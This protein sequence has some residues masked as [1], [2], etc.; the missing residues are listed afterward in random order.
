M[1]G[2][3]QGQC[4]NCFAVISVNSIGWTIYHGVGPW[5]WVDNLVQN[6]YNIDD[7]VDSVPHL[8]SFI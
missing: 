6:S 8:N 2:R 4:M 3:E 1:E 7:R 5:P